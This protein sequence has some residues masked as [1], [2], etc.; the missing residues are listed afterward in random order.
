MSLLQEYYEDFVL[1]TRT[2]VSDGYGGYKT[3]YVD[4]ITIPAALRIDQS[5]QA[6]RAEKEG[7]TSVYTI[8]TPKAL[9]LQYHDVLKRKKDNTTFRVTSDGDDNATPA[10]ASLDMRAVTAEKWAIP[11][12]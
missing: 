7:V 5:M 10:T 4:G 11:D 2:T 8:I 9:N 1:M 3:T 12:S 6:R